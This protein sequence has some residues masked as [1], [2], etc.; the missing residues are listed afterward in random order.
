ADRRYA[1]DRR[2][3][4]VGYRRVAVQPYLRH[5]AVLG[6]ADRFHPP[7]RDTAIGDVR[8]VVDAAARNEVRVHLV[9]TDADL[10]RQVQVEDGDRTHCEHRDDREDD[11][12][13]AR[14][15][16]EHQL[17]IGRAHV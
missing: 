15:T 7:D 17:Q 6:Q 1:L 8:V 14:E 5:D 13:D 9:G 4:V 10:R 11:Q 2:G 16:I 3:D 12:L